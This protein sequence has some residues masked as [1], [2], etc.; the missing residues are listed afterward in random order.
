MIK[1]L[2]IFLITAII[3]FI[4]CSG[5][6]GRYELGIDD[7]YGVWANEDCELIKT[8]LYEILFE[9]ANGRIYSTIRKLTPVE[10]KI[11]IDTR[12][13]TVFDTV[14]NRVIIKAKDLLQGDS[15]ILSNDDKDELVL[16]DYDCDIARF[17]DKFAINYQGIVIE[18]LTTN[19]DKLRMQF[20]SGN[21]QTLELVEKVEVAEPYTVI[22]ATKKHLGT[23][24]QQ[25]QLGTIYQSDNQGNVNAIEI[26]TNKHSYVFNFNRLD[27]HLMVYCRAARIRS[28]N[29]GTVFSQHIRLMLNRDS[30]TAAMEKDNFEATAEDIDIKNS[31]F[32]PARCVNTD[33]GAY[34]SVKAFTDT[35]IVINGTG[36]DYI[37]NRPGDDTGPI[38]EW[39][40]FVEY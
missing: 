30:F 13:M 28:N 21:W 11:I 36:Q 4:S 1:T 19:D 8:G 17:A 5:D 12:G 31:L 29:K 34:W 16:R 25:W 32:D 3:V 39:F 38:L 24:L 15:I 10:N 35:T 2:C 20:P 22:K 23:C 18:E 9:R 33:N 27:D 7:F 26:Q 14:A 40:E 37:I 6:D